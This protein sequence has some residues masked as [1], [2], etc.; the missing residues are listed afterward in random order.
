MK[1]N[2]HLYIVDIRNTETEFERLRVSRQKIVSIFPTSDLSKQVRRFW[3]I[4]CSHGQARVVAKSN[5]SGYHPASLCRLATVVN[6]FAEDYM[7]WFWP[8]WFWQKK[9]GY[10]VRHQ[11]CRIV[12]ILLFINMTLVEELLYITYI[13]Q[14]G[15]IE[16]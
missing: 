3:A 16:H 14:E 15:A 4:R 8:L 6:Q 1:C 11:S 5:L 2:L 9:V 13:T 12:E 10:M 7:C